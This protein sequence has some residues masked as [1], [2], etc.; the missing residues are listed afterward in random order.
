MPNNIELKESMSIEDRLEAAR[1]KVESLY[2]TIEEVNNQLAVG[3]ILEDEFIAYALYCKYAGIKGF[4][5]RLAKNVKSRDGTW[6]I[7]KFYFC[8]CEGFSNNKCSEKKILAYQKTSSRRGCKAKLKI[9]RHKG[10]LVWKVK[11]FDEEHN[12]ELYPIDQ[13]YLL[14][15]TWKI[16]YE[17]LVML[18][19]T[20]KNKI[21]LSR[22]V[23]LME[24][25]AGG[26]Q[27]VGFISKDAYNCISREKRKAKIENEDSIELV[28]HFLNKS[29]NESNF[30]WNVEVDDEKRLMN[31][32]FRD[33]RCRIDYEFFGDV[34]SFDTT[35]RTNKYGL[36]CAP[37]VGI[38]HHNENV[39]F[40]LAFLSDET[41]S[42]LEWLFKVFLESMG[43]KQ[44]YMIFTNQCQAMIAIQI[45]FSCSHHRLC[46]W[47][48]NQNAPSHFGTL[49]GN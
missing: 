36:V 21:P 39:M 7:G 11:F 8:S 20:V 48:I 45:V 10:E 13:A 6:I 37:F 22:A 18:N 40:G 23:G 35:Y 17:N 30:F 33:N 41:K 42:S 19:S 16:S 32:F 43:G 15:S 29:N 12:H 5:V 49:N 38:N 4:S 47:H 44:P 26:R 1:R 9:G 14:R 27:N 34:L 24:N 25:W 2:L 46:Q 3:E 31:F 28:Q